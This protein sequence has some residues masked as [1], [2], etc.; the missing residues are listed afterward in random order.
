MKQIRAFFKQHPK[1]SYLGDLIVM[2][3]G[4]IVF[5]LVFMDNFKG[6]ILG[7]LMAL[8]ITRIFGMQW[9]PL[10]SIKES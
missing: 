5:P 7:F 1:L 8:L 10:K 6:L 4:I 9:R 2:F 3:L